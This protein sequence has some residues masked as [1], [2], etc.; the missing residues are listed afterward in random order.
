[1]RFEVEKHH[2]WQRV[3]TVDV[4]SGATRQITQV[5]R[6]IWEFSWAADGGFVLIVGPDHMSGRG[7]SHDWREVGPMAAGRSCS[8]ARPRSS[9]HAPRVSP[10]GTQVAFLSC[11]WSDRGINGGDVFVM[12]LEVGDEG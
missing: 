6:K 2:R 10:N 8:I 7:L 11:I 4:V 12:R 3:W 1:M 5:T 9:S